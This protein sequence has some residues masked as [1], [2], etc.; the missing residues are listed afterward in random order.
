[1]ANEHNSLSEFHFY[2]VGI[3]AANKKLDSR[4]I[5]VVPFEKTPFISGEVSDDTTLSVNAAWLPMTDT[6]RMT[7][8]DVRRGEQVMIYRFGDSNSFWWTTQM[9]DQKLRRKET[10]IYGWSNEAGENITNSAD[11]MIFLEISA[12]KKLVTF[13]TPKN[14]GEPFA[15]VFQLNMKEGL[16]AF[17]DGA[18]GLFHYDAVNRQFIHQNADGTSIEINQK[19]INLLAETINTKGTTVNIQADTTNI[20]GDLNVGGG[21]TV[22]KDTKIGGSLTVGNIKCS[23]I[24]SSGN[25]SAPNIR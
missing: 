23:G 10:V 6:N 8:P 11:N 14:D 2:S 20:S 19:V 9:Q 21:L 7:P 15:F 22:S 4:E 16:F 13:S 12:H 18:D 1:M 24:Q 5:E 17:E 25:V 3:V